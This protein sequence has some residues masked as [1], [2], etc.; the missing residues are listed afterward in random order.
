MNGEKKFLTINENLKL[1]LEIFESSKESWLIV[2]HGI[3]EHLGRHKEYI[4]ELFSSTHNIAFYDLR[5]HGNSQGKKAG[6]KNLKVIMMIFI[7]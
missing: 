1:N 5:G 3:G 6:S 4:L 2:T 7:N